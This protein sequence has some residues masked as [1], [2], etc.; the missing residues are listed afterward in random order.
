[1]R[2]W[3]KF[4]PWLLLAAVL[5]C[6]GWAV[7]DLWGQ[8]VAAGAGMG[9]ALWTLPWLIGLHGVQLLLSALA[10]G[11]LIVPR[12]VGLGA[13]FL[14]RLVREGVNSLLPVAHVGGE[15]VAA[16]LL[17]RRG[18]PVPRAAASVIV[19]VT[20]EVCSQVAFLAAGMLALGWVTGATP[21]WLWLGS[22]GSAALVAGGL[23][24]GQRLG[25]LRL[26]ERLAQAIGARFPGM[27][28][29]ALG[30]LAAE[31]QAIYARRGRWGRRS[32]CRRW[33]GR[34]GPG[35]R[36]W[37]SRRWG[38]MRRRRR[39]SR[40][41]AWVRRPAAPGSQCRGRWRSRRRGSCWRRRRRGCRS[42]RR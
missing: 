11:W 17:G 18:V 5:S 36:G 13:L 20:M 35:R 1:M 6:A 40:W 19:D 16:G 8:V 33:P 32:G 41:R 21:L 12:S 25:L 4:G 27:A 9:P 14:L 23:V 39:P 7:S 3:S 31:S 38:W 29:G 24:L 30:G 22:V 37:C 26:L 28:T 42:S 10:W 34:W 15:V 2:L